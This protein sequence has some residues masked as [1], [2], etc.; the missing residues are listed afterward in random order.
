MVMTTRAVIFDVDGTLI[1]SVDLHARAWREA[2]RDFG[3]EVPFPEIRDHMGKGADQLMP[4]FVPAD[5]LERRGKQLQEHR[6]KVFRTRYLPQVTAFPRVADLLARVKA[7]G[8][9]VVL[10]SSARGDELRAYKRIAGI[11]SLVDVEVSA[12]DAERSKPHADI[13]E[14]ALAELA[15]VEPSDVV[16]VGDTPYDAVAATRAGLRTVGVLSGGFPENWLTGAGCVEVYE[17]AADLLAHYDESSLAAR[18]RMRR[19]AT[20]ANTQQ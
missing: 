15:P 20:A 8:Q 9:Q 10:A 19:G 6:A 3:Y 2:L 1:D 14:A 16:V 7:D 4:V 11:D 18:T 17:D 5:D 12:D 13:F